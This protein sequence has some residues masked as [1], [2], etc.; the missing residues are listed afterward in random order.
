MYPLNTDTLRSAVSGGR[1]F[2]FG[3]LFSSIYYYYVNRS[4]S[5]AESW[6]AWLRDYAGCYSDPLRVFWN[7]IVLL[8]SMLAGS[9]SQLGRPFF[10]RGVAQK[11]DLL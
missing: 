3:F 10:V 5:P 2:L 7:L 9:V 6:L 8:I 1:V 4:S 11:M